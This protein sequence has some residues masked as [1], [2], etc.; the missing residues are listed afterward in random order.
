MLKNILVSPV[1]TP[2]VLVL[3]TLTVY[4]LSHSGDGDSWNYFILLS[5]AFLHGRLYLLENPPWLNELINWQGKYYVVYPPMPAILLMPFVYF[6]GTSFIQ[7]YLS[8]LIGAVNVFLCFLFF[9]KIFNKEIGI[10]A[11]I[12]YAF[13]TIQWFHASVGSAWYIAHIIALFFLWL[14]L[15]ETVTKKRFWL[16]GILIGAAYW[17]RLPTILAASFIV[18]FLM[19]DFIR[20]KQFKINFINIFQFG[21]GLSI[22]ILLNFVYNYLRFGV[23]NDISYTLLPIFDEPWYRYG[24]FNIRYIPTH[25]QEIFTSFPLKDSTFPYLIPSMNVMALWIVT[26]AFLLIPFARFKKRMV[27]SALAALII[28]SLPSLMHGSNGFTQFGYRFSLDYL[29]F[30]L[31][32]TISGFERLNTWWAKGLIILS[33]LVNLWGVI[34]ISFLNRWGF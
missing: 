22:F 21:L 8:I 12:L 20:F 16:I 28:A 4:Y 1:I 15:I 10:W 2:I 25:L 33:I 9:K 23:I 11:S 5:D 32:L 3:L 13:G 6:F 34:M 7:A 18:I 26:P 17:S 30:L 27:Y 29:P 24:L 31:I 14:S 19:Q